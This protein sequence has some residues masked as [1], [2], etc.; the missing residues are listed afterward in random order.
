M[1]VPFW[2][3]LLFQ[4]FLSNFITVQAQDCSPTDNLPGPYICWPN[5]T[6]ITGSTANYSPISPPPTFC[7]ST[8]E[9]NG[10]FSFSPCEP[11]VVF[12]VIANNC[13]NGNGVE[14]V[15]YDQ[16]LNIVSNC[17]ASGVGTI[18]GNVIAENLTPGEIYYFMIDGFDG[19]FCDFI[20]S[21]S[22]GLT[23]SGNPNFI[24]QKGYIE[25]SS[26]NC[27]GSQT[28]YLAIPPICIPQNRFN[29]CP[30][31]DLT[32]YYDTI[33]HWTLPAG[34]TII[35]DINLSLIHI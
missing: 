27:D 34:G 6:N 5:I 10:W 23:P 16:S 14:A 29:V 1:R 18:G 19:D 25:G 21:G 30:T 4:F 12:S 17:L 33:Y 15:I 2:I 11:R 3:F 22:E 13:Q 28:T 32:N 24:D 7:N 26:M 31:P 35:G 8:I 9:N 20:I